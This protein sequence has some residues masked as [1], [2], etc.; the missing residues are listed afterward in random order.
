MTDNKSGAHTRD[1]ADLH[2]APETPSQG[3]RSGGGTARDVGTRDE[4]RLGLG[5]DPEPTRVTKKDKIQPAT[6]TRSDHEGA[7]R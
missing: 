3:G 6:G 4:E 1:D 5:G 2:D 7:S